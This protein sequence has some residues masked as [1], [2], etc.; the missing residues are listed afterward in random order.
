MKEKIDI[1]QH[2]LVPEHVL[3]PKE[4]SDELLI[5]YNINPNQ[6][7]RISRKDPAIVDLGPKAGDI[8]KIIRNSQT[9]SKS[10]YYRVVIND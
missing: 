6:L 9:A 4:E 8:I 3:L 10:V 2:I 5:K 1:K 7:P